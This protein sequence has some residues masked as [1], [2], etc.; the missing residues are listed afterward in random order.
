MWIDCSV[1]RSRPP[2][3]RSEVAPSDLRHA[4]YALAPAAVR[5]AL[6]AHVTANAE[7]R[8]GVYRM[9]GATGLVLY[10]GKAKRLR[11]RLLSYLVAAKKNR[12][13]DKQARILR[14][15]HAV[16]WEY[17]HDE[18][19]AL[20]REFRLIK[21]HRP[22]FNVAMNVDEFPRG[23]VG[24][25]GGDVPGLRVVL[26]SDDPEA[27]VLYGPFRR[28]AM[29]NEA[30]RALAEAT[31]LR[32]CEL[33]PRSLGFAQT[34]G[35]RIRRTAR[36]PLPAS[37]SP[38]CLRFELGSCT[39]PCVDAPSRERYDEQAREVR[40]FL[41]G[42]TRRPIEA[43]EQAMHAAAESWHFERA[44]SLKAKVV[45]LTWLEEALARFHAGADRLTFPYRAQ[46]H[47]GS[48]RVYLIRRGTVRADLPVPATPDEEAALQALAGRIYD[49]PDP[50]GSD[51]PTHDLEE[52]YL[53]ASWFRRRPLPA[54]VVQPHIGP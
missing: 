41:A 18:F 5:K 33:A 35:E 32:D 47:D 1:R 53:V 7:N 4:A 25:T 49:G 42:R 29:L 51:I 6:R 17:C 2:Q 15:A 30:V 50:K 39:G 8:P 26:R 36:S 23:W 54:P 22:R 45:A 31:G 38:G 34:A 13:R 48:E 12:R 40:D 37:R 11:T 10:V 3:L 28:V 16:D 21:L 52:F 19:A 14:M 27:T 20:L 43:L 46:G 9:L 44:G 24:L